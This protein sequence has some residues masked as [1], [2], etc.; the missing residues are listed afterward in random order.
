MQLKSVLNAKKL[1]A[2]ILKNEQ[3]EVELENCNSS[4]SIP[5]Q[6]FS[7]VRES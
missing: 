3:I 5:K 4:S 1:Q 6:L 2:P 7:S